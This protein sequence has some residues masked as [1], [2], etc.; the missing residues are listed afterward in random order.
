MIV[1]RIFLLILT[2][3]AGNKYLLIDFVFKFA[4]RY[5]Y[6]FEVEHHFE[7]LCLVNDAVYIGK[8]AKD[9]EEWI[10][11]CKKAEAKGRPMPTRWTATGT[12]FAVPYVFK[13][14]N[15][16]IDIEP[17]CIMENHSVI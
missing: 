11:A 8:L 2:M 5:G 16:D 9:D 17:F 10:S 12:Q 3:L 7:K 15:N 1:S 4:K 13:T 14:T 6:T